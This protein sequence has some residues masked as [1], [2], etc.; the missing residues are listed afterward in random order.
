[1]RWSLRVCTRGIIDGE[2]SWHRWAAAA[3]IEDHGGGLTKG[4][5]KAVRADKWHG[6]LPYI[7][8]HPV[9]KVG[10][11]GGAGTWTW[12]IDTV[13]GTNGAHAP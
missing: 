12:A 11:Q 13:A 5:D 1:V 3:R 6:S 7:D 2:V 9:D 8:A 4:A 10:G